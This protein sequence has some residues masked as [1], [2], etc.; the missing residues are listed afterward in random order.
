MRLK[1]ASPACTELE[2]IT[3]D[4]LANLCHLPQQF[5]LGGHGGGVIQVITVLLGYGVAMAAELSIML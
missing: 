2:M 1:I 5:L 3:M 4:W